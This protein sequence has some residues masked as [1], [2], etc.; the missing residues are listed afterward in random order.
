MNQYDKSLN[1]IQLED[2]D[3]LTLSQ[4]STVFEAVD[5]AVQHWKS[6]SLRC[7]ANQVED[8]MKYPKLK[9]LIESVNELNNLNQQYFVM[10]NDGRQRAIDD[11]DCMLINIKEAQLMQDPNADKLIYIPSFQLTINLET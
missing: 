4:K 3:R 2:Y 6:S 1:Q 9:S 7:A 5:H 10:L 8:I 11:W